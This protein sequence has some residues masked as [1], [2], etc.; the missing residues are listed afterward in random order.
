MCLSGRDEVRRLTNCRHVFHRGYLDRW[1]EHDQRPTLSAA[2]R[3]SRTRWPACSGPPPPACPTPPAWTSSTWA[4]RSRPCPPRRCCGRTS[5]CSAASAATSAEAGAPEERGE[6]RGR[7]GRPRPVAAT[8][9]RSS[10]RLGHRRVAVFLA[11]AARGR[12]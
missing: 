11:G 7:A 10:M 8:A 3:S 12:G 4:G 6:A 9:A 5:C 2:R 1:M